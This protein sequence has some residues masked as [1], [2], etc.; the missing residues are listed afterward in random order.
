MVPSDLATTPLASSAELCDS[1]ETC[2]L[3]YVICHNVPWWRRLLRGR[4]MFDVLYTT[5]GVGM[6]MSYAVV[7]KGE[8]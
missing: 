3:Q 5:L 7:Q 1:S 4:P 8:D 2:E 6:T